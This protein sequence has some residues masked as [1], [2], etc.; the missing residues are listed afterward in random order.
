[1]IRDLDGPRNAQQ[2]LFYDLEDAAAVIGW[3][4]VELKTMA[5][6]A[7][8]PSEALALMKLCALLT[9]QHEKLGGYAGEVKG[10]RIV[11]AEAD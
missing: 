7:K 3:S 2:E 11:R 6:K 4:V 9:A 5:T 1:M 10:Q 8:T